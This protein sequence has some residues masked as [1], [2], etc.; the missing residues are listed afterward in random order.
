MVDRGSAKPIPWG[1]MRDSPS[2]MID[3]MSKRRVSTIA[4]RL[5]PVL[6]SAFLFLFTS[7]IGVESAWGGA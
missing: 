6:F 3:T 5:F 7:W 2:P 1:G 4:A